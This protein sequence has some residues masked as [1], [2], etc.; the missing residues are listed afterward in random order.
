LSGY[1]NSSRSNVS[2]RFTILI[3]PLSKPQFPPVSTS[4]TQNT[5]QNSI[6]Y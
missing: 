4:V 6:H 1:G 3:L 2:T 5:K